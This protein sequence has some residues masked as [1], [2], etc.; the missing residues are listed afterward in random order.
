[1]NCNSSLVH[2]GIAYT[3]QSSRFR[4]DIGD[5]VAAG[6]RYSHESLEPWALGI[7]EPTEPAAVPVWRS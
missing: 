2:Q 4:M 1:M 7:R 5:P 6:L 3:L